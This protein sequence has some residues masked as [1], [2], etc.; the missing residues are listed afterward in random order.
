MTQ[1]L[2]EHGCFGEYLH[3]IGKEGTTSCHNCED[4]RDG[5]AH[6]GQLSG[7]ARAFIFNH[8]G[9]T[10]RNPCSKCKISGIRCEDRLTFGGINHSLRTDEEYSRYIDEDHHKE[11]G[12]SPLSMLP[13]GMVSQIPFEYMHLVCLGVVKKLLSAWVCGK[14]TRFSKLPARSINIISQRLEILKKYCPPEFA[15]HPR[16]IHVFFKYKATEFRQFLLYTGPVVTHGVLDQQIYIHFLFLHTAIRILI[17]S[18]PSKKYLN[19]AELALQKFVVRCENLYGL[20]FISYNVHG[21]LHLTN[22]VRQLGPLDSFSAFPYENNMSV[23][24]KYCRKPNFPLQQFANRMV[25]E[26]S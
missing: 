13:I 1:V 8:K 22:D 7:V 10:S 21:L 18:L 23:F 5:A 12:K 2:T 15:R 3:R 6:V 25:D 26:W 17:S 9:H 24:R 4:E 20:S 14:Y 16:A 11:N 19:F